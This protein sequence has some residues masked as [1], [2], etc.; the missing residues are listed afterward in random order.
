[1]VTRK[2]VSISATAYGLDGDKITCIARTHHDDPSTRQHPY[3]KRV[4]SESENKTKAHLPLAPLAL[5]QEAPYVAVVAPLDT[6]AVQVARD[7]VHDLDL[8]DEQDDLSVRPVDFGADEEVGVEERIVRDVGAA[9][10]EEPGYDTIWDV[11][12]LTE[13]KK[14]R[15]RMQGSYRFRRVP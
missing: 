11:G 8:V 14:R 7:L 10:V 1:M 5:P 13:K 12:K 15:G 2:C 3:S 4:P 6:H 9:E